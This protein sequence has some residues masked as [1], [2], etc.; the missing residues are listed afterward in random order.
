MK[1][2]ANSYN[3]VKEYVQLMQ[4]AQSTLHSLTTAAANVLSSAQA[5][6]IFR[7]SVVTRLSSVWPII[8][9]AWHSPALVRFIK[10]LIC[11]FTI[12]VA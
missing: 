9:E 5:M 7:L 4:C 11:S 2:L 10:Q 1:I 6:L 8:M 3:Y 12:S